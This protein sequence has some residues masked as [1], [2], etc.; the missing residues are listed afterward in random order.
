M[1][2]CSAQELFHIHGVTATYEP[3]DC[4]RRGAVT[5]NQAYHAF[6]TMSS[7]SVFSDT[8]LWLRVDIE[9]DSDA[10]PATIS[11]HE[12]Q[13]YAWVFNGMF[14]VSEHPDL[15]NDRGEILP[16][17]LKNKLDQTVCASLAFFAYAISRKSTC[18]CDN[19]VVQV[20]GILK[21]RS[22]VRRRRVESIYSAIS[23]F[24]WDWAPLATGKAPAAAGPGSPPP[25]AAPGTG[26]QST[27][28]P[29]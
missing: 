1:Q 27:S 22:N 7:K 13:N 10:G 9:G 5:Y 4:G 18:M 26:S 17:Y 24:T 8:H 11:A 28:S 16:D 3:L 20:T 21:H 6:R 23:G 15:F 29:S 2:L 19:H 12:E 25:A 14:D